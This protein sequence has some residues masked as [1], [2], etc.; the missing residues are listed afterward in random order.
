MHRSTQGL[1]EPVRRDRRAGTGTGHR[2]TG[3]A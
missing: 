3:R 2:T 1:S